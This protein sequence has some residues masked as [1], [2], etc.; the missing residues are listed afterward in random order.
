[1]AH[2]ITDIII[3]QG[4]RYEFGVRDYGPLRERPYAVDMRRIWDPA[5]DGQHKLYFEGELVTEHFWQEFFDQ[6]GFYYFDD[7]E[8]AKAAAVR[9][10]SNH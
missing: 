9:L 10:A 8:E 3:V 1:M 6:S 2:E 7:V 4:K 5:V